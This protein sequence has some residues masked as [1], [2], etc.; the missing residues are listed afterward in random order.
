MSAA[1]ADPSTVASSYRRGPHIVAVLV[2]VALFPLV[3]VGAG[4]TSKEVGLAYPD[5]PTSSG[6]LDR[7]PPRSD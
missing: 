4:V 5:W 3:F 1:P 6:H 7:M 2:A